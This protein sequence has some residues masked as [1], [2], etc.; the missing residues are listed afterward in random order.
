[1]PGLALLCE[2]RSA[3]LAR[4]RSAA[5]ESDDRRGDAV[6]TDSP[7][8]DGTRGSASKELASHPRVEPREKHVDADR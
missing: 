7:D 1:M 3:V 2:R 6:R 8:Y 5:D 4:L